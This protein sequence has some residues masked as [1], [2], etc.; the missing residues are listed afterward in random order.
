MNWRADAAHWRKYRDQWRG[1]R[2]RRAV[3]YTAR[4][5]A[6]VVVAP[7]ALLALGA[8]QLEAWTSNRV[9]ALEGWAWPGL[10]L[11]PAKEDELLNA[12][13]RNLEQ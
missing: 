8:Q 2:W 12:L 3:Y 6:I 7:V 11:T 5:A 9:H 10:Y 4:A 1:P 13:K